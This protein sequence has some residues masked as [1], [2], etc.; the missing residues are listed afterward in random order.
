MLTH[1]QI[2]D[3]VANFCPPPDI[4]IEVTP[5]ENAER[6]IFTNTGCGG[7][8]HIV[9]KILDRNVV[10]IWN[11]ISL[12]DKPLK[13]TGNSISECC[14]RKQNTAGGRVQLLNGVIT[15]GSLYAGYYELAIFTN[16]VFIINILFQRR[17]QRI[18]EPHCVM[19]TTVSGTESSFE[20]SEEVITQIENEV[21]TE[22]CK[23]HDVDII[24]L[25]LPHIKAK[26]KK[27][28]KIFKTIYNIFN[29]EIVDN[30][31]FIKFN[32]G[33]KT[34]IHKKLV[35]SLDQ[36]LPTWWNQVDSICVVNGNQYRPDVGGW[37][38]KPPLSQRFF[39]IINPCPPPLL[40]IEMTYI[41]SGDCDNAINK[42]ARVQPH[43]PTTEFVIVIVPATKTPLS[44]NS[45][46][47]ISSVAVKPKTARPSHTPYLGHLSA[48]NIITAIQWYKIE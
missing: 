31:L 43:C 34:E 18:C 47:D 40:W 25:E 3:P 46:S 41:N 29:V 5:K 11:S 26:G 36:Q 19:A 28:D 33:L 16:I 1:A 12:V 23:V 13:I 27:H 20:I 48:G 2:I 6:K 4:W 24:E 44:A 42:F 8:R 32:G 35:Y 22:L 9:Q 15:Q 14:N 7:S 21:N 37:N 39:S 17:G 38:T 30:K 45:N 10:Q